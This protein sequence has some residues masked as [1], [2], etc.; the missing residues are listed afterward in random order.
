MART[1]RATLTAIS[2]GTAYIGAAYWFTSSTSF[3]NPAVTIGRV[4]S[5]TFAGIAPASLPLFLAG[6]ILGAAIGLGL[7]HLFFPDAATVAGPRRCARLH[8][9]N[10]G[11]LTHGQTERLVRL[12]AQCRTVPVGGRFLT[13]LSHGEVE[14]RSAG[15]APADQVNPAAVQAMAEVGIDIAAET[16]KTSLLTP[17]VS[18]MW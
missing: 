14:V 11:E 8:P 13:H 18:R 9:G 7:V 3:A 12:C 15:S 2:V 1:G 17:Y 6:Q 5:D 16:P 4:F 10:E